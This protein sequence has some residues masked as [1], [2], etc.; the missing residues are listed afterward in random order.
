MGFLCAL[1]PEI[2]LDRQNT[3][4]SQ[5]D[6]W[7]QSWSFQ[8]HNS[9]LNELYWKN[10]KR[11]KEVV[12]KSTNCFYCYDCNMMR[13]TGAPSP[14]RNM[15]YESHLWEQLLHLR[16]Q[17]HWQRCG[18]SWRRIM[19]IMQMGNL[20]SC[21]SVYVNSRVSTCLIRLILIPEMYPSG[22][23]HFEW[24]ET[25]VAK[26]FFCRFRSYSFCKSV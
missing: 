9:P 23:S 15:S 2:V 24:T 3:P 21:M 10:L 26:L 5:N 1:S 12:K 7:L 14:Q 16:R 6:S 20:F 17:T 8:Q 4:W 25:V 18:R 22:W 13:W 19:G 11:L